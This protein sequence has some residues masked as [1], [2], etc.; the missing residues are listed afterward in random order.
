VNNQSVLPRSTP[1]AQG[2][3]SA[4]ILAFLTDAE[5]NIHDLHSFMLLRHG[6][7]VADGWWTPY[8]PE[9]P[10]VLFSLSK[11]F[12]STAVGLAVAEGRLSVDDAVVDFFPDDRPEPVSEHLAAMRVHHLLSMSTGHAEDTTAALRERADGNWVAAFL[13]QPVVHTPGSWFL[14]NSGAT[15]LLSAI[16]QKLT[17][18]TLL[19]Y[20]Q[21]RLFAPLGI[22]SPTW[23]SCPRGINV[24]GWGLSVRTE[25]IARF[26]QLYLQQGMWQGQRLV[27][28]SWIATATSKQVANDNGTQ[29]NP[30]WRQGYGYQ[31]WR[32]QHGAYRGDGAFGQFCIVMPAQDAVIAITAGVADMQSVLDRIWRHLLP[33][34]E[35][36]P[37][38]ANPA[39]QAQLA[40]QLANLALQPQEGEASSPVAETVSGKTYTFAPNEQKV[41]WMQFDF[42]G[43]EAEVMLRADQHTQQ[44]VVGRGQ[45][46]KGEM[47]IERFGRQPMVASGAWTAPDTFV[48]QCYF[49]KTPFCATITSRFAADHITYNLNMNVAFGPTGRPQ[50]LGR[51]KIDER[52]AHLL[53]EEKM[54]WLTTLREDG[55]PLPT[56][57]WF[58]WDGMSF[59]IFTEPDSLKVKNIRRNPKIAINLNTDASGEI[60]AIFYGEAKLDS[61]GATPDERAAYVEKYRNGMKMIHVSPEEHAARWS[62]L[63]R[64]TPSRVRAQLDEPEGTL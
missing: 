12:T 2:I 33:V 6:H 28:A 15:Y 45:W 24:G 32:C 14:Y 42:S 26:G 31:F 41:D 48:M 54:A 43:E 46:R 19:D 4:A 23:E 13:A 57:I 3:P 37:L 21:P 22:V 30:D 34:M 17:G 18:M 60:F 7:V 27:P 63:I 59:L 38:P 36:S 1:E 9:H 35:G 47:V 40:T 29:S 16:I 61:N 56:P 25:D 20:L 49:Y 50:L 52:L 55:M 44:I 11:S 8:A 62:T 51:A 58:W 64:F 39:G 10:H 53:C 5:Q